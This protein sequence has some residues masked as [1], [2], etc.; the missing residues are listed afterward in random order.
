MLQ[1]VECFD[2]SKKL[3]ILVT[4]SLDHCIRLW[5]PYVTSKPMAVLEGH[6]T[7]VIGV[8]I[9]EGLMQVFSYSKDAVSLYSTIKIVT[10]KCIVD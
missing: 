3:N 1:G 5:N 10:L 7:G 2:F 4:G 9:H 8:K 6:S